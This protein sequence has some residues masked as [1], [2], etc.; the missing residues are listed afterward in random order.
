M[1]NPKYFK[2]ETDEVM[3]QG[4]VQPNN[5][6]LKNKD[7]RSIYCHC[8]SDCLKKSLHYKTENQQKVQKTA[9]KK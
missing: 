7:A 1:F 9:I 6:K 2:I 3:S 5:V 4:F 8:E